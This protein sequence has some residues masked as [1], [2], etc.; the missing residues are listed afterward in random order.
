MLTLHPAFELFADSDDAS[1]R[2]STSIF[3]IKFCCMQIHIP[4]SYVKSSSFSFCRLHHLFVNRSILHA[5]FDSV[6]FDAYSNLKMFSDIPEND[7]VNH[8]LMFSAMFGVLMTSMSLILITT[9][10]LEFL[11]MV[12][13][14]QCED[15]N[16]KV[17]QRKLL[18]LSKD[19]VLHTLQSIP[20]SSHPSLRPTYN[21]WSTCSCVSILLIHHDIRNCTIFYLANLCIREFP[22]NCFSVSPFNADYCF[23]RTALTEQ[24]LSIEYGDIVVSHLQSPETTTTSTSQGFHRWLMEREHITTKNSSEF[25]LFKKIVICGL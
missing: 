18:Q 17:M 2:C 3:D 24:I 1:V 15:L 9:I 20:S 6:H 25:Q 7:M 23:S 14:L 21:L 16:L 8:L 11:F 4:F 12:M 5:T 10:V 19:D 22:E 13:W